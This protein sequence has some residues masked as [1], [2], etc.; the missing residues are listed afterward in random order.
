MASKTISESIIQA[1]DYLRQRPDEARYTDTEAIATVEE[2]LRCRVAGPDGAFIF[3]DMSPAVGGAGSAP[4]PGWLMRAAHASCDATLIA[5]RAAEEGIELSR[6]QVV[7]DSESDNRGLLGMDE[8]IPAG[9]LGT[10]VRIR[11]EAAG[12]PEQKLR[13]LVH[14]AREHSPVDEAMSRAVPVRVEVETAATD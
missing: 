11:I 2:G 3:S 4:S 5:M 6:L 9:P 14:W 10:R 7:V 13:E 8:A 12:V 1:R